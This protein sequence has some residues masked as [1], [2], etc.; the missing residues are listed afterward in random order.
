MGLWLEIRSW[1]AWETVYEKSQINLYQVNKL[2]GDR[3]CMPARSGCRQPIDFKWLRDAEGQG[4]VF[5][6]FDIWQEVD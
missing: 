1:F 3:R 2:T 6:L 4:F 5:N